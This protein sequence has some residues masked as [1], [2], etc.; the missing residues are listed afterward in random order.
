MSPKNQ[1][2]L[3]SIDEAKFLL[4]FAATHCEINGSDVSEDFP[5][6]SKKSIEEAIVVSNEISKLRVTIS[7]IEDGEEYTTPSKKAEASAI[8]TSLDKIAASLNSG[9]GKSLQ[10][11]K[12]E[13][14]KIQGAVI[15]QKVNTIG[16]EE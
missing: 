7:I 11:I 12:K 4:D 10:K 8:R 2:E 15:T 5:V 14:L 1:E 6:N 9:Y 16:G 3:F 13:Y